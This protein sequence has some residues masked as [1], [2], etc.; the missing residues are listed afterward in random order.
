[1]EGCPVPFIEYANM[2]INFIGPMRIK[3]FFVP[4]FCTPCNK[5]SDEMVEAEGLD[6]Q[7]LRHKCRICGE[8]MRLD[9]MPKVY[10]SFLNGRWTDERGVARALG[11]CS[12]PARVVL[13]P[14]SEELRSAELDAE[15]FRSPLC[16]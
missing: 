3:S 16:S 15:G 8:P 10:F 1:L 11:R 13:P 6:L 12:V 5:A 9:V 2:L 14:P 4:Y 7:L